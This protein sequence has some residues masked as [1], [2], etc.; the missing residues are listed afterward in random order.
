MLRTLFF[1]VGIMSVTAAVAQQFDNLLANLDSIKGKRR[2][3]IE[4]A[5]EFL[6]LARQLVSLKS[7]FYL[8]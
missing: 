6:P 4:K 5:R 2:E 3:N 1:A 7:D 8:N